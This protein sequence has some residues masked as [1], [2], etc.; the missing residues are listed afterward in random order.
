MELAA[1]RFPSSRLPHAIR[2]AS[3]IVLL[4][5]L[6]LLLVLLRLSPL[7]VP[8]FPQNIWVPPLP[9]IRMALDPVRQRRLPKVSPSALLEREL[10]VVS[11]ARLP[12]VPQHLLPHL[13]DLCG[14]IH[15]LE[16]GVVADPLEKGDAVPRTLAGGGA[17][18]AVGGAGADAVGEGLQALADG[19]DESSG[20]GR[21]I[22]PVA[23]EILGLKAAV[24]GGLEEVR[25]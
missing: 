1:S 19:H 5:Q 14:D 24:R 16:R 23:G 15:A 9:H 10:D 22:D 11:P 7:L 4:L 17:Q 6:L 13:H 18:D 3:D 12:P 25:G 21:A 20:D 8:Y 2:F